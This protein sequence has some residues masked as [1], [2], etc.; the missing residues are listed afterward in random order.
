MKSAEL[1]STL[2]DKKIGSSSVKSS[3]ISYTL[4]KFIDESALKGR[5][6][7]FKRLIGS[8]FSACRYSEL[9]RGIRLQ[10]NPL[11]STITCTYDYAKSGIPLS[12]IPAVPATSVSKRII[13]LPIFD[14]YEYS[15]AERMFDLFTINEVVIRGPEKL[16]VTLSFLRKEPY[17]IDELFGI[18]FNTTSLRTLRLYALMDNGMSQEQV[19]ALYLKDFGKYFER[20]REREI[21]TTAE[22]MMKKAYK[23]SI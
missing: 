18:P 9:E 10:F 15:M 8:Y 17:K 14:E 16:G 2:L 6:I 22:V 23:P 3:S 5:L 19:W 7:S 11:A 4:N 20:N 21:K 1:L 12:K 13:T